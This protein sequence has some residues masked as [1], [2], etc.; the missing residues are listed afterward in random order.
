MDGGH[1][2]R[3]GPV[4]HCRLCC[5]C[6]AGLDVEN[7]ELRTTFTRLF[8]HS[9]YLA[10]LSRQLETGDTQKKP[11]MKL[12]VRLSFLFAK[13]LDSCR[14]CQTEGP[15]IHHAEGCQHFLLLLY[16]K[17]E[18]TSEVGTDVVQHSEELSLSQ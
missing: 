5:C 9:Y 17:P 1:E 18:L 13:L 3:S 16:S 8:I 2:W 15:Q 4:V 11:L 12:R 7:L 14:K 10:E 6:S